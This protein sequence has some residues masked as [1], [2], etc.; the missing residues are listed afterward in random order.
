MEEL[1][2]KVAIQK[3]EYDIWVLPMHEVHYG[4]LNGL[5]ED[6]WELVSSFIYR[7]HAYYQFKRPL[8]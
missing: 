2:G 4:A 3:W 6:G 7:D 1:I 8:P 5:G